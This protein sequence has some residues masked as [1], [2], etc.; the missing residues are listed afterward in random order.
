VAGE[1][2]FDLEY[3]IKAPNSARIIANHHV[4]GER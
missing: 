4:G 3:R 2:Y 1:G